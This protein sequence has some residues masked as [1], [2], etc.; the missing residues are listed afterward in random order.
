MLRS[1][2]SSRSGLARIFRPP[3]FIPEGEFDPVPESEL[4]IDDSEIVFDD[5]FSG[6][7]C[8]CDFTILESL[9]DKL[10]N[11]L[12]ALTGY[13]TS[14]AFL[15]EHSSLRYKRVAS[16]TRLIPPVIPN[17]RKRRLKCA[18]TVRRAILS[19]LAISELSQPCNSSSTICCSRGPSRTDLSF[20]SEYPPFM[21]SARAG[22]ARGFK[23]KQLAQKV[24]SGTLITKYFRMRT[25]LPK[26]L[27]L[28][29][30]SR[31]GL[32]RKG[33]EISTSK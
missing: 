31:G 17:R 28:T 30:P 25:I 16:F 5:M 33:K 21:I 18:F 24:P 9:S 1:Q 22:N 23:Q 7:D 8:I 32:R 3:G 27:A 11:P 14:V 13:S 4:V 20:I 19:C 29:L 2:L 6:S 10:D 12:L 15:S 26:F